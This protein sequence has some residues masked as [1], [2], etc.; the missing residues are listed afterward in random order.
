M[1]TKNNNSPTER[2]KSDMTGDGAPSGPAANVT[3]HGIVCSAL[4]GSVFFIGLLTIGKWIYPL[5]L[6][7]V[8]L[9]GVMFVGVLVVSYFSGQGIASLIKSMAR[10]K[11]SFRANK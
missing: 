2:S 7:D 4:L 9:F 8:I 3:S 5:P 10:L 1:E 6:L 11:I